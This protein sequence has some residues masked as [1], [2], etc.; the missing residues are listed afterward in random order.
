MKKPL[1]RIA[2]VLCALALLAVGSWWVWREWWAVGQLQ[3]AMIAND[4]ERVG[5]LLRLGAPVNADISYPHWDHELAGLVFKGRPLHRAAY[6]RN[7]AVAEL[8][9]ANGAKVDAKDPYGR[10]PLHLAAI[11]RCPAV[12]NLLLANG[13]ELEAKDTKGWTPLRWAVFSGSLAVAKLLLA[14]GAD[15]KVTDKDG[16]T[17][18]PNLAEIVKKM[19]AEKA[20][21]KQPAQPKVATP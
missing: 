3:A 5:L 15:T 12:V 16:K 7:A 2:V 21:R 20:G 4:V 1:L 11:N 8:L 19:A 6:E 10:T 17:L 9:L 18:R 14:N 13:A